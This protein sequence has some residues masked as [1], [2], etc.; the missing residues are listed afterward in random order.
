[1]KLRALRLSIYLIENDSDMNDQQRILILGGTGMLG[2]ILWERLSHRF[3][4]VYTTIRKS[5]EEYGDGHL[6]RC[7]RV[8]DNIDVMDFQ[9]FDGA[10]R[11]IKP[12]VILNCIGL[13]KRRE[14]PNNAIPSI[15]LN[16]LFPH[17]L[18]RLAA[19]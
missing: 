11:V 14:D 10:V 15:I 6:F 17:K 16:A 4:N 2:H 1:M 9:F 8:I 5:R 3:P 12:E 18:A 13:T 7:D 19:D